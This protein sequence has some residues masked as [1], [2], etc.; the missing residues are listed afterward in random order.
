MD[1]MAEEVYTYP[2]FLFLY[3]IYLDFMLQ[4]TESGF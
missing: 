1:L 4:L 3:K 2:I